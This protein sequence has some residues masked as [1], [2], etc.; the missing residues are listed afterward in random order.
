M[1]P[2]VEAVFPPPCTELAGIEATTAPDPV[3]PDTATVYVE[4]PPVTLA[5]RFPAAVD[6]SKEISDPLNPVTGALKTAV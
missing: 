1:S 5:E 6:P 3:I 2:D 4:G